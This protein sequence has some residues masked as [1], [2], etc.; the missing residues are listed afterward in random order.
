[1]VTGKEYAKSSALS[2]NFTKTSK[3]LIVSNQLKLALKSY[4]ELCKFEVFAENILDMFAA[5]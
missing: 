2:V 5:V 1:M 3:V 4:L